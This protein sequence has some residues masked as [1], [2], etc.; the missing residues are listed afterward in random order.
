MKEIAEE[1][2]D[3]P[4][5]RQKIFDQRVVEIVEGWMENPHQV[6]EISLESTSIS[7]VAL[8]KI[9]NFLLSPDCKIEKLN[10]SNNPDITDDGLREFVDVVKCNKSLKQLDISNNNISLST[11]KLLSETLLENKQSPLEHIF[12]FSDL[13]PDEMRLSLDQ[14]AHETTKFLVGRNS[15]KKP[16][17]VLP[18]RFERPSPKN[19]DNRAPS[20]IRTENSNSSDGN[21]D[22]NDSPSNSFRSSSIPNQLQKYEISQDRS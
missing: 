11:A 9:T 16:D 10:L 15:E 20:I 12:F 6:T 13:L 22:K 3:T 4:A 17:K 5:I 7:D 21:L 18:I 1:N 19:Q 2:L 14:I 8:N